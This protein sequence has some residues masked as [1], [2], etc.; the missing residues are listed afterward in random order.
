MHRVCVTGESPW[1]NKFSP[2]EEYEIKKPAI[3]WLN[4]FPETRLLLKSVRSPGFRFPIREVSFSSGSA[5]ITSFQKTL[6]FF[7][8]QACNYPK[9]T[10]SLGAYS[11][12][13]IYPLKQL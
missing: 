9:R 10:L 1:R 8:Q 11:S 4:Y 5:G 13:K 12:L 2:W 6:Y 7:A 3:R